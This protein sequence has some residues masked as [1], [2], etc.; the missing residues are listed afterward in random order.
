MVMH[1]ADRLEAE[2]H[3]MRVAVGDALDGLQHLAGEL[4]L[5]AVE[6]RLRQGGAR[7]QADTITLLVA[8]SYRAGAPALANALLGPP[9]HPL[10]GMGHGGGPLPT[11]VPSPTAALTRVSYADQPTVRVRRR[12]GSQEDWPFARYRSA[13]TM[14]D[15][16]YEYAQLIELGYPSDLCQQQ[17]TV[18]VS[19]GLNQ[20]PVRTDVIRMAVREGDAAIV[21]LRS[22]RLLGVD[23]HHFVRNHFLATGIKVFMVVNLLDAVSPELLAITWDRL[24]TWLRGGPAYSGQSVEDFAGQHDIFFIDVEQAERG[25][26]TGD[27]ALVAASG[28]DMLEWRLGDFLL[29]ERACTHL[30]P[31]MKY[32]EETGEPIRQAIEQRKA[33]RG[34]DAAYRKASA[35][36]MAHRLY[37]MTKRQELLPTIFRASRTQCQYELQHSFGRVVADLRATLPDKLAAYL[38][39]ALQRP[40]VLPMHRRSAAEEAVAFCRDVISKHIETWAKDEAAPIVRQQADRLR[41][42]IE[43]TVATL[44]HQLGMNFETRV[45]MLITLEISGLAAATIG[46]QL[47]I[48]AAVVVGLPFPGIGFENNFKRRLI[49]G[50]GTGGGLDQLLANLSETAAVRIAQGVARAFDEWEQVS[51][52]VLSE[53]AAE[54]K[55]KIQEVIDQGRILAAELA[56]LAEFDRRVEGSLGVLRNLREACERPRSNAALGSAGG[57]RPTGDE[58]ALRAWRA[59][60]ERATAL[61]ESIHA[62]TARQLARLLPHFAA[63]PGAI[64]FGGHFSSGKSTVLNALLGRDIL[65]TGDFP[66]TGAICLIQ[67]GAQDRAEIS[68]REPQADRPTP[69]QPI[70]CTREAIQEAVSL[71][72]QHGR[73]NAATELVDLL[74]LTLAGAPIPEG[75]CWIDSPGINDTT[76]M[77]ERAALAAGRADILIW[78]LNSRQLLAE[79]EV[80]FLRRHIA[81]RGAASMIFLINAFLDGAGSETDPAANW[82]RFLV[83]ALPRHR[84][85]VHSRVR[86][87]GLQAAAPPEIAVVSARAMRG[88]PTAS[89]GGVQLRRLMGQLRDPTSPL[90]RKARLQYTAAILRRLVAQVEAEAAAQ[91]DHLA[92]EQQAWEERKLARER[93]QAAF[94][95]KVRG[96]VGQF[97]LDWESKANVATTQ[98][99]SAITADSINYTENY[100]GTQLNAA[101]EN[102]TR[103]TATVL[104]AQ[105]RERAKEY[106]QR[107]PEEGAAEWAQVD[108]RPVEVIAKHSTGASFATMMMF[109]NPVIGALA[110]PKAIADMKVARAKD[111]PVVRRD[112]FDAAER[113][114]AEMTDRKDRLVAFLVDRCLHEPE[115][116]PQ[117]G[118]MAALLALTDSLQR[119]VAQ[120]AVLEAAL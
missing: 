3:W 109:T 102:V 93:Q 90:L 54:E 86:E 67:S 33:A 83:E 84:D 97:L 96:L 55:R 20:D 113:T 47:A 60:V 26:F 11:A 105:V 66:E 72:D 18:L 111:V 98:V 104:F 40:L 13:S 100:H 32:G 119:L 114:I 5:T 14:Q 48:A 65:P 22:D 39:P 77:A 44:D 99:A 8:G 118:T 81:G 35:G 69:R 61:A 36:E 79:T 107:I 85:K 2:C 115:P 38:L 70:P 87:M 12:D 45:A 91:R 56:K 64:A 42:E 101:L 94:R 31:F 24:V 10:P 76:T 95:D 16:E 53:L 52:Q 9:I 78:V 62:P 110:A 103:Q 51:A 75:M 89:F 17:V 92:A 74:H 112:L 82:D 28:L 73:A 63:T 30:H 50:T 7:L 41:D 27:A 88:G 34:A 108:L 117:D 46:A 68:F 37:N 106:R 29:H 4:K 71:I 57:Y 6:D 120:T 58:A 25:R 59:A 23:E 49:G 43:A 80:D 19:P 15:G 1:L 116:A 21:I